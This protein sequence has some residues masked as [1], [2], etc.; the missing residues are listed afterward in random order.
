[1]LYHLYALL[2]GL[3]LYSTQLSAAPNLSYEIVREEPHDTRLFTQGLIAREN[4]LIES[5]GLYGQS[6]VRSYDANSGATL[7]E[8]SLPRAHFAEGITLVDDLVYLL[9]WKA[10][11]V[12]I[13]H[14]DSLKA[15]YKMT[16]R[17]EGWGLT[18]DGSKLIMS[19][20]SARL[21]FRDKSSFKMTRNI[22]V[23]DMTNEDKP[24]PVTNLNE[25]EYAHDSV[26]ANIWHS[27]KIVR[28]NPLNG[29]VSGEVDLSELV[30]KNSRNSRMT[31]NGI[32]YDKTLDAFWVTGKYW[33][34]RYL[35]RIH[36]KETPQQ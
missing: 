33:P 7:N 24:Q 9:T 13:L 26:W 5:S 4:N 6:F 10:G 34:K 12:Y 17:G 14:P 2:L 18:Y 21:Y 32:A 23:T 11:I 15:K 36:S 19:D 1:M 31:L 8:V 28:I 25:L 22:T 29:F 3:C 35:I 30:T 16:Y 20:G 27:S